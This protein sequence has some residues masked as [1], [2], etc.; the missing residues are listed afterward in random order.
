M[1][2]VFGL[3]QQFPQQKIP[4]NRHRIANVVGHQHSST[5]HPNHRIVLQQRP[6]T[7][8]WIDRCVN[9]I[10][11]LLLAR[12]DAFGDFEVVLTQWETEGICFIAGF[13]V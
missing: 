8:P 3:V 12:N 4:R 7:V 10:H 2:Q 6:S 11:I 5:V 1:N 9:L 13:D